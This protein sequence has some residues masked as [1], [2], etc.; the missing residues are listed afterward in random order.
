[1]SIHRNKSCKYVS[2]EQGTVMRP[3]SSDRVSAINEL[4]RLLARY[5]AL[6]KAAMRSFL[7]RGCGCCTDYDEECAADK[8]LGL[9]V[10][11]EPYS[12]ASGY[13]VYSVAYKVLGRPDP[14]EGR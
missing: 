12:D 7:A 11:A 3:K 2:G 9:A 5:E 4:N 14:T 10:G 13:D 8:D 6:E 1:M